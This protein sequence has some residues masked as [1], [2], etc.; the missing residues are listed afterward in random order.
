[1]SNR[2][3][4]V[5]IAPNVIITRDSDGVIVSLRLAGNKVIFHNKKTTS[6]DF[7]SFWNDLNK[8]PKPN[9]KRQQRLREED[10]AKTDTP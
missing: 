4:R 1:M 9:S 10:A 3:K 5:Q 7:K 6:G 2:N 8:S